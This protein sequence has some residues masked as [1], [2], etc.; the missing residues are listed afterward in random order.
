MLDRQNLQDGGPMS[1]ERKCSKCGDVASEYDTECWWCGGS[2]PALPK[3]PIEPWMECGRCGAWQTKH[4]GV[5][6]HCKAP[7]SELIVRTDDG[8]HDVSGV[9]AKL[10]RSA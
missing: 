1:T 2:L 4:A 5:C 6:P 8:S 3:K 7:N 9:Y 10:I